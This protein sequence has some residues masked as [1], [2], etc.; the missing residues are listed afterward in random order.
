[1]ELAPGSDGI[2]EVA[3]E[4]EVGTVLML[5]VGVVAG[6]INEGIVKVVVMVALVWLLSIHNN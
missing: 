6:V 1:M 3:G 4:V 2:H 5:V